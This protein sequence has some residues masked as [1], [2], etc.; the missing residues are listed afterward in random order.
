MRSLRSSAPSE[1]VKGRCL[2][3][4]WH[5]TLANGDRIEEGETFSMPG[6]GEDGARGIFTFRARRLHELGE[7]SVLAYGGDKP[8]GD[9]MKE[10]RRA[11]R[12]FCTDDVVATGI[13]EPTFDRRQ[14]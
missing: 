2:V 12:S 14:P 6:A 5:L 8:K 9:P 11:W 1:T 3:W 13:A 7:D 10:G 4:E